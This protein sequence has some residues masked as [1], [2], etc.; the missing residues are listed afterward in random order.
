VAAAALCA[1]PLVASPAGFVLSTRS[2]P[3]G[4]SGPIAAFGLD[5][6]VAGAFGFDAASAATGTQANGSTLYNGSFTAL[7]GTVQGWHFSDSAG[8]TLVGND[9]ALSPGAAPTDIFQFGA[10]PG[11]GNGTHDITGFSI[12][13]Y[14]LGNVRLFWIE[15]QNGIPDFL[16][17]QELLAAPPGFAGRL[18]LDF[19]PA[20]SPTGPVS[21]V[22][23]DGL[24]VNA[25]PEP[26]SV[27]LWAAGSLALLGSAAA[28]QRFSAG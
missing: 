18:A 25:V 9:V 28:R 8:Y 12:P 16:S 10:D 27:W 24:T 15:A 2:A 19:V 23:F 3:Y 11:L 6:F 4:S 5:A 21:W 14:T 17:N 13:G 20:N 7:S 22:F 1:G 26:A